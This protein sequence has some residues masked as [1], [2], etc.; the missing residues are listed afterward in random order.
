MFYFLIERGNFCGVW[1]GPGEDTQGKRRQCRGKGWDGQLRS[2]GLCCALP[3][4]VVYVIRLIVTSPTGTSANDEP[5]RSQGEGSDVKI[6]S[7]P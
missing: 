7:K 5:L 6:K 4:K 3:L 2:G 1:Q